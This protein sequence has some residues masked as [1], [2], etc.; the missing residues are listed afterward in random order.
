MAGLACRCPGLYHHH[1][2][3]QDLLIALLDLA[4]NELLTRS[5][6]ARDEGREQL[7]FIR[8]S[9]LRSLEP[10]ARARVAAG[11][12]EHQRMVD[13][14]VVQG[15]LD[16]SFGTPVPH[17]AARAVVTMCSGLSQWFQPNGPATPEQVAKLYVGFAVDLVQ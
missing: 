6:S 7:G 3:K 4:T 15:C 9:E 1:A 10:A 16:G 17:A 5:R 11:G 8:A 14:E 12:A 13:D 2:S